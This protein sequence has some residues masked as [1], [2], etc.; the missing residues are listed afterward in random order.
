MPE[1][2]ERRVLDR[3]HDLLVRVATQM[4]T[5]C[6]KH[7]KNHEEVRQDIKEIHNRIDTQAAGCIATHTACSNFFVPRYVFYWAV[8]IAFFAITFVGGVA[9]TNQSTLKHHQGYSI[10]ATKRIDE[11]INDLSGHVWKPDVT[12]DEVE[13]E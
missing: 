9:L 7:D 8:V 10:E 5:L 4:E 6:K 11:R 2:M 3:D 13:T 12:L 1:D